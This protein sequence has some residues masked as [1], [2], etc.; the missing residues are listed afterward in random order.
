MRRRQWIVIGLVASFAAWVSPE[1][2]AQNPDWPPSPG[3]TP[4]D[5]ADPAT[6]P[7]DQGFGYDIEGDGE[8]CSAGSV[9]WSS[10]TGGNWNYWS[11]TPPQA[12]GRDSFRDDEVPMGSGSWTDMAWQHTIGEKSVVIA[13]LDSG[14]KWDERD[15]VNQYYINQTELEASGLDENCLPVPPAGHTGDPIDIDGDGYLTMADYLFGKSATEADMVTMAIDG[16]GN[17]NGIADPGDLITLCSDGVDDDGNGYVDDISGWDTYADDNDPMDDNRYGHG[18]SEARWSTASGNDGGA[19]GQCPGC[20]VLMVRTGDSFIVDAQDYAQSVIFSVDSGARVVQEA[21]G[22]LNNTTFMRRAN[23]Y[24]YAN[25]V[26]IIAS[27]ADENSYHHNYPGT[28]NHT[29]YVHAITYAGGNPQNADSYLA[30]NNCTNY[31]GQLVL[32]APGTACSSNA[33]GVTAG[34]AG[35][36]YSASVAA[37]RPGGPLDPPLSAEE[38]RQLLLMTAQDIDVPESQP[39]ATGF[40]RRWY[41]SRTGW[42]QRF[43]YGRVNTY[44]AVMA[45]RNGAIPPEVDIVLPDWFKNVYPD[46]EPTVSIEGSIDAPRAPAFD[47]VVEWAA[48]IEPEEGDWQ[49]LAM[50]VGETAPIEGELASWDVSSVNIDNGDDG[51]PHN[52]FTV[53]VRVRVTAKYADPIGDVV[54]EGRRVFQIVRDSDLLPGFPIALGVR[55]DADIYPA[56][57]GEGSAKLADVDNDGVVEIVYGDSDGL[58]HAINGDATEVA[59]YPIALG[60]LRGYEAS[61]LYNVLDSAAYATGAVPTEDLHPS[62]I[63]NA[64]AIGDLDGDGTPEIVICTT[65]GDIHA[66]HGPDGSVVDGF[67]IALPEVPSG[68]PLRMG[69]INPGSPIER[70]AITAITL[71]DLDGDDALELVLP[72][73]D[74]HVYAFRADGSTQPGFPIEVIAPQLWM[75]P[76][77]A[78]PSRI[79]TPAAVGDA[80]GDGMVD[81]AVGSNEVGDDSNSGAVHLYHG[82]GNLHDGGPE[83]DNWPITI[84]SINFYPFIGEGITSP[85]AMADVNGDDKPD[86]AAAGQAGS[87]FI[88]DGIQPPR[89]S[90][91]DGMPIL[92]LDSNDRGYSSDVSDSFD[93]PLLNTFAAGTFGDLDQDGRPEFVTGGAGLRL[94]LNLAGGYANEPFTHQIGAWETQTGKQL[95]G[96]PHSIED[97]LFFVNPTVVNVD[98]DPYPEVVTGSGGYW[99]HAWDACGTEADGFPKFTGGWVTGS[100]GAGDLDDDGLLE[101]VVTTRS[102]YLFAWNTEAP[103]DSA[104]P[105]PEYR[106]DNR[107]TGNYET[108][109]SNGGVATF[110]T[111]PLDCPAPPMMD[112]GTDGG[113]DAGTD[114]G[115]EG[116]LGG[117]GCSCRVASRP[118]P[119]PLGFGFALL[120]GAALLRRRRRR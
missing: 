37:D 45:V 101:I 109:L 97:Y 24:A 81:I 72:A 57:S 4:A 116:D 8:S 107:N 118:K 64:P 66:F 74:G 93:K 13:V 20:R 35:V 119:A 87:I 86:I 25:D 63:L 79:V 50:G 56:A 105:W 27:A 1:I 67:P 85:I 48:G 58:L 53:T 120:F 31:G 28:A 115:A 34:I 113:S 112:G 32:S 44:N 60:T 89:D 59:G 7:D 94:G 84:A 73:Y 82:D 39:G 15:L 88:W 22:S 21:L 108:E 23:D 110:A 10:R 78:Q 47:Y 83:H 29:L 19:I 30:F 14:I 99:V 61:E 71:V 114:V 54:G 36:V 117:G 106:H 62:L 65:E 92:I 5:L 100:V 96:Y 95:P 9:C 98:A 41:P 102:G 70:G 2:T 80:D 104:Q 76:S 40:D 18:T 43:G 103:V 51:G 42:D 46:Q 11:W 90:G 75:D 33:T 38:L 111:E 3:S 49:T 26:L 91:F 12:A 16:A 6:W 69:P 52:R 68:D 55:N 77:S 17:M